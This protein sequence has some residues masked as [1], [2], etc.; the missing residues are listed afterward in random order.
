MGRYASKRLCN[1]ANRELRREAARRGFAS[2]GISLESVLQGGVGGGPLPVV[3]TYDCACGRKTGKGSIQ[4]RLGYCSDCRKD[5]VCA[6]G[7]AVRKHFDGWDG[8]KLSCEEARTRLGLPAETFDQMDA[9]IKR[10]MQEE[11]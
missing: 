1:V 10:E 6:C 4:Y 5:F 2:A 3:E 7:V 9:R 8:N 11:E